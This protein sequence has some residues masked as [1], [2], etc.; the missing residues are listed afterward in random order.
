[1]LVCAPRSSEHLK[2][3]LDSLQV[4]TNERYQR[5]VIP[6]AGMRT[7]CNHFTEDFCD[8]MSA[9]LPRGLL[10]RDQIAWLAGPPGR[11]AGWLKLGTKAANEA[12]N[13]G[14]PVLVC[15]TNPDPKASSHIAPLRSP[16]RIA[17]AGATNFNDGTIAKGF[18]SRVVKCYGHP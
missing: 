7:F 9:P 1:M 18:G 12:V 5:R 8:L 2:A 3:I 10:A 14:Q 13:K 15:W 11:V 17:Q 16:G 6:G 4:E